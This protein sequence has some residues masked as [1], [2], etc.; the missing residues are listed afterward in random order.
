MSRSLFSVFAASPDNCFIIPIN[1]RNEISRL[2]LKMMIEFKVLARRRR[3]R[4]KTDQDGIFS[5]ISIVP[6]TSKTFL[7]NTRNIQ[8]YCCNAV[9]KDV[10]IKDNLTFEYWVFPSRTIASEFD[11]QD[12]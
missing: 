2:F 7:R 8:Q 4:G 6:G 10:R 11:C 12:S 9:N 3:S 1:E 5:S